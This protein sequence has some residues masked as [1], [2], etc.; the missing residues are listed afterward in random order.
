MATVSSLNQY[1]VQGAIEGF[2]SLVSPINAFSYVTSPVGAGLGDIVRVP[3]S[4]NTSGSQTFAYATG[5]ATD[6]NTVTGKEVTLNTLLYQLVTLTDSDLLKLNQE[7]LVRVGSVAGRKLAVDFIS[8]SIAATV[9]QTNFSYSSSVGYTSAAYSSSA[10]FAD[11][12]K[13][14]NTL[15]W[16]AERSL[17]AGTTLWAVMLGN[18]AINA[19]YAYG[20]DE[21]IKKGMIPSVFGF[22][23]YKTT[24]TLPNS[25]TG[26]AVTP[27]GILVGNA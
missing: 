17:I 27:S 12:D 19:A 22:A 5:Y 1:L 26:F 2:V 9:S 23:G 6:G 14:A 8:A 11:L 25:D 13:Q 4:N 16:P 15:N 7:A 10:A 18:S 20:S 3:Y 21:V 24:L